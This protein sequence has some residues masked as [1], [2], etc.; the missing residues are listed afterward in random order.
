MEAPILLN[1]L[2]TDGSEVVSPKSQPPSN[3]ECYTNSEK[4]IESTYLLSSEGEA[5]LH[6]FI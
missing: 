1:N 6:M 5:K 3:S 2:L 4:P